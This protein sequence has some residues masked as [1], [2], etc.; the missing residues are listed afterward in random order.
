MTYE[1][2]WKKLKSIVV[3]YSEDGILYTY[4]ERDAFD[5]VFQ[6]VPHL[7]RLSSSLNLSNSAYVL[8]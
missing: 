5:Q 7:H 3:D 4:D 6:F 8:P 2:M 1:E